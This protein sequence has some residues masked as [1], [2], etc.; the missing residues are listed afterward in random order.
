[1]N[2]SMQCDI[3]YNEDTQAMEWVSGEDFT[4]DH[5]ADGEP[6]LNHHDGDTADGWC[7]YMHRHDDIGYWRIVSCTERFA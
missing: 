6:D 1:M 5:W 4:Y 7:A 3:R 2:N